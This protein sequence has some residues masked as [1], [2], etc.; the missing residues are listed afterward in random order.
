MLPQS[1]T[2]AKV[3]PLNEQSACSYSTVLSSIEMRWVP[4]PVHR[5]HMQSKLMTSFFP[6]AVPGFANPWHCNVDGEWY[7]WGKVS[8][9]LEVLDTTP[10]I[11]VI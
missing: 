8:P 9:T 7:C 1:V 10:T 2:L 3:L 11:P 5:V 4:R 6:V